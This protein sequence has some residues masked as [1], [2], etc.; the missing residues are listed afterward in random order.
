[1]MEWGR[2]HLTQIV[3]FLFSIVVY[4]S[5]PY[6]LGFRD[7]YNYFIGAVN[8]YEN[9]TYSL[10]EG[11]PA[12]YPMGYPLLMVPFFYAFG[13]EVQAG[14][15]PCALLGALAVVLMFEFTK[16]LF[17]K[18]TAVF[19]S[20]LFMFSAH[21]NYSNAVMSDV[22]ALFFS[23][24][25][26]FAAVRYT[27]TKKPQLAFLFYAA[28]ALAS[29]MRYSSLLVF[30][31]VGLYLLL[32]RN[33]GLLK[34][35]EIWLGLLL[36][37]LIVTPQLLYN[38][39]HFGS[40]FSTGYDRQKTFR[41]VR[42]VYS[43][44]VASTVHYF[45]KYL[46]YSVFGYS[47]AASPFF[48]LGLLFMTK[49]RRWREFLL[50]VPWISIPLLSF[51][52]AA[53]NI[54]YRD[55]YVM[56]IFP[57]FI[58]IAGYGFA[59]ISTLSFIKNRIAKT[60]FVAFLIV[61]ILVPV[62]SFRYDRIRRKETGQ[63]V[64][65]KALFWIN[66]NSSPDDVV[67]CSTGIVDRYYL[68]RTYFPLYTPRRALEREISKPNDIYVVFTFL[69]ADEEQFFDFGIKKWLEDDFSLDL[70]E[71]FE[72]RFP[73]SFIS[74]TVLSLLERT[75]FKPTKK[76]NHWSAP[77]IYRTSVYLLNEKP[78]ESS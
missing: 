35:K 51:S 36:A 21:W 12:K 68:E 8:I 41:F 15:L 56:L 54:D 20:L 52:I 61:V 14:V 23:V 22:P 29:L 64:N 60:I 46:K 24:L 34:K 18:R 49:N 72:S 39:H 45:I 76:E 32:S 74:K 25:G 70:M 53:A 50:F 66:E 65:K 6:T 1:M 42:H 31:I 11:R 47:K 58:M 75:P 17:D 13:P 78:S 77:T 63:A 27:K 33:M 43:F 57:V 2:K 62:T 7:D 71:E 19:A 30:P 5:I 69:D 48:L 10:D 59:K 16:F 67:F 37:L 44:D 9:Q 4:L 26:I 55:R 3:F 40:P 38:Y 73:L 28:V